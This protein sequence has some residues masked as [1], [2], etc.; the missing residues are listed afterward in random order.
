VIPDANI[1]INGVAPNYMLTAVPILDGSAE[2]VVVA[3]DSI[4]SAA[5]TISVTVD[6]CIIAINE[7]F[8]AKEFEVYP[9][10]ADK[11]VRY[12]IDLHAPV[13]SLRLELTDLHGRVVQVEQ[14]NDGGSQFN[15]EL[16]VSQHAAGV[17]FLRV[18]TNLYRFNRKLV[19]E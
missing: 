2:I 9:N 16:D 13:G 18:R 5:D 1:S 7:S 11:R 19:I 17:Y 4:T 6:D 15:G 3:S 8:F 12:R 10:P 14:I